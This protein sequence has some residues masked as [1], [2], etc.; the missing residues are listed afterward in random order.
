MGARLKSLENSH[1]VFRYNAH[2]TEDIAIYLEFE[3]AALLPPVSRVLT[4]EKYHSYPLYLMAAS[5]HSSACF[6]L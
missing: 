1:G 4:Q 5:I 6:Q 3:K 2:K